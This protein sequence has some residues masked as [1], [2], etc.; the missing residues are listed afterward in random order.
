M[1]VQAAKAK[2]RAYDD[3]YA[4]MDSKEGEDDLYWLARHRDRDVKDVQQASD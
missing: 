2:Q 3:L 1:K 4:R